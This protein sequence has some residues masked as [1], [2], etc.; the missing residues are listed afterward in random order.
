MLPLDVAD[1]TPGWFSSALGLDVERADVLDNSSGTTGR[2][3]VALTGAPDTGVPASV[4]VKLAPFDEL[5]REFVTAVGMGVAEAR[6]YRDIA[7]EIPM[8]IPNVWYSQTEGDGYV[9]VLEDLVANGCRFPHPKDPDIAWRALDIVEQMAAL[10]GRFWESPRFDQG[11]DLAWLARKG[12]G[13]AGGGATFVQMAVDAVGDQLPEEFHRLAGIYL[14]R[15]DDI[16]ALWN[17]GPRTLVHGD[18]HMGNLFVDPAIVDPRPAAGDRTGFLDWAMIGRSPGLRDVAYVL[19]NSVPAAVRSAQERALLQRYC[20]LLGAYG[21]DLDPDA[22][23]DQYRLF[24][25][26]SWVSAASTAG[27]GSKWQPLHIGLGGTRRATEA[28]DQ[29]GCVDLLEHLL[30]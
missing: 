27:M 18:P 13:A 10:H 3:R 29:L 15:T 8:R 28:C 16:V 5:Q 4:F 26:Y 9:M 17:S 21:I 20:E 11:G 7:P 12:T 14:A 6:F 22:A 24:A 30:A 25:V 23:W 19:C 2:A 1:L